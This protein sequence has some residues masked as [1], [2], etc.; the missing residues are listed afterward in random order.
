[1]TTFTLSLDYDYPTAL[2]EQASGRREPVPRNINLVV[3]WAN[4]EIYVE[5]RDPDDH[6]VSAARWNGLE[7]AYPLPQGVDA[8]RL[9]AW[10][11]EEVV[12]RAQPL[13]DAFLVVYDG[14]RRV[15]RFPGDNEDKKYH[16]DEWMALFAEPPQHSGGLWSVEDWLEG[17]V[18][19]VRQDSSDD[20]LV[21]LANEIVEEAD[22]ANVVL[23][24]GVEAV[25][26]YLRALRYSLR[27]PDLYEIQ[28][29]EVLEK[30]ARATGTTARVLVPRSWVEKR[31][32]IVRIDP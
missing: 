18:D 1:M 22:E 13:A 12:P 26:N 5:T 25:L 16:F 27:G 14:S 17:G 31:V 23:A 9:R 6:T 29:Y 32:K 21:V 3:D 11:E 19:E 24:G 30:T 8:S 4:K 7:D 20:D 2:L 15:G 28:G 10:V